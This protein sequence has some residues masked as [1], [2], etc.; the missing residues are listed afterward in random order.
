[1]LLALAARHAT[2]QFPVADG[3]FIELYTRHAEHG[4]Q[5]LGPYS[6]FGWFHPGPMLFYWLAAFY[7]VGG[8]SMVSINTGSLAV[9]LLAL[10]SIAWVGARHG[11]AAP[12]FTIVFWSLVAFFYV[13][14]PGLFVSA[15]NPHVPVLPLMGLLFVSTAVAL[16][17]AP[18]LPVLLILASFIVQSHIGF[19]PTA[20]VI[21]V[22]G[23]AALA[24]HAT[25]DE[26]LRRSALRWSLVSVAVVEL[27][28]LL[29]V[30]EQLTSPDGNMSRI[31]R[32]F[33]G[34]AA[35]AQ[36]WRTAYI[37]WSN[38]ITGAFMPGFHIPV[39]LPLD[40]PST[41][42]LPIG[43]PAA[44]RRACRRGVVIRGPPL[45]ANADADVPGR[46]DDRVLVGA[47]RAGPDRRLPRVLAVGDWPC[48]AALVIAAAGLR[49][50]LRLPARPARALGV[51]LPAVVLV[52][53]GGGSIMRLQQQRHQEVV[54]G[55]AAAARDLTEILR[56]T[57]PVDRGRP[58]FRIDPAI[59]GPG[60]GVMLQLDKAN[61]SFGVDELAELYGARVAANGTEELLVVICGQP[62]HLELMRDKRVRTLGWSRDRTLF[63]DAI[64]LL[65]APRG[66]AAGDAGPRSGDASA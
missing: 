64:S 8:E 19:A 58:V 15:W 45:R 35:P 63:A 40:I 29:P 41:G 52:L 6:Q 23:T 34:D 48:R 4:R 22:L 42:R 47:P 21:T 27:A 38:T 37:V 20:G 10:A 44:D 14:V 36:T 30:A 9:N 11:R 65:D 56:A 61:V 66:T 28:W 2:P 18:L 17:D 3:A 62:R 26:A 33:F 43:V 59:W 60:A 1:M 31:V 7:A 53:A 49:M 39:G 51:M 25:R 57:L 24:R 50:G 5:L 13:R 55:E 12:V 54:T 46:G 16:A 32:F